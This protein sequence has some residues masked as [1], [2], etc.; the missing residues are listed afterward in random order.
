[1]ILTN[2]FQKTFHAHPTIFK[3]FRLAIDS[4]SI[5]GNMA[6]IVYFISAHKEPERI[7][8]LVNRLQGS[9]DFVHIHFGTDIEKQKVS[10]W[11]RI[12][13]E[14]CP[15]SN[16]RITSE[17]PCAWGSF[18]I[19]DATLRAMKYYE[20][21]KYDYFIN[22]SGE[23][24]PIK[25]PVVIRKTL[26]GQTSAFIEVLELPY[27]GWGSDGGMF[28]IWNRF[29]TIPL[30][31]SS[32]KLFW[33]PRLRRK[34]PCNLKPYGGSTWF[35]MP[36]RLVGYLMDYVAKNPSVTSFF[37]RARMPDEMFFQTILMGSPF[38]SGIVNDN[39]RY[40][41]WVGAKHGHPRYLTSADLGKFMNSDK[42]F[43]RKF[44]LAEDRYILDAI[45]QKLDAQQF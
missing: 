14:D 16:L 42:L 7:S 28:R 5:R 12:L 27:C 35:C 17:V 38:R 31:K 2:R 21:F 19:V 13:E 6:R 1:M 34:L 44:S 39:R 29:Y 25:H 36:K 24:Y 20:D 40:I 22:L 37:R 45:D 9:S 26:D 41:D 15:D 8:R 30:G 10:N 33:I 43:A 11:S 4:R 23:C 18:G 3:F 32:R